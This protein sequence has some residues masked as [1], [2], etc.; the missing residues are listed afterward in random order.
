M[1]DIAAIG[2]AVSGLKTAGE[3]AGTLLKLN[4]MAEVAGKVIE[5]QGV[6]D[7]AQKSALAAN[8]S[9]F[10]LL[11]EKRRL[12]KQ[13]ADHETWEREKQRYELCE[14]VSGIFTYA[15]KPEAAGREPAHHLCANCYEHGQKRILQ[16]AEGAYRTTL[17]Q[18]NA[19]KASLTISGEKVRPAGSQTVILS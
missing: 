12:E 18:C 6:I 1:F 5:L 13:I 17:L 4:N 15:L 9:Q 2:G 7:S 14:V 10:E 19:C 16:R 3:I 11:E 8:I